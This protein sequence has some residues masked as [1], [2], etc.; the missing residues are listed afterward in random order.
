[1]DDHHQEV[2]AYCRENGFNGLMADD[3]EYAVFDPPRYFSSEH[4]KLTY[5][6]CSEVIYV[7][8]YKI[9]LVWECYQKSS[10]EIVSCNF[11]VQ[12]TLHFD[13]IWYLGGIRN[14]MLVKLCPSAFL[15]SK[16]HWILMKFCCGVYIMKCWMELMLDFVWYLGIDWSYQKCVHSKKDT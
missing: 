16:Q 12:N 14:H 1:M 3:G 7:E 9:N 4:L 11:L 5:K 8:R 2:I 13:E 10:S 15:C 6:V